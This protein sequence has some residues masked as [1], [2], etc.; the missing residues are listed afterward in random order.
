MKLLTFEDENTGVYRLGVLTAKGVLDISDD[1]QTLQDVMA[2]KDKAEALIDFYLDAENIELASVKD[3]KLGPV[4][5]NPEKIICVGVNYK[6]HAD[7]MKIEVPTTPILFSKFNNTIAAH[8]ET[9]TIPHGATTVDYE[10]ELAIIIGK[11]GRNISR[12]DAMNYVFGYSNANDVSERNSQFSTSQWLVGKTYDGFCP[13]GPYIV[14]LDDLGEPHKLR[15]KTYVNDELRQDSNTND[16]IFKTK[17]L[18]SH[19]SEYMTLKPGDIILTGT[20]EGVA[21]GY[22]GSVKP[23]LKDGDE[24][25]VEIESLGRL[26]NR[27]EAAK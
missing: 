15:I 22:K 3:L 12:D 11:E 17:T 19:I 14:T 24:V 25:A 13:I 23:W 20:P 5:E 10:G 18:I 1:F 26:V 2:N 21:S 16:M 7:E 8:G 27:F 6:R 4:V 9:I